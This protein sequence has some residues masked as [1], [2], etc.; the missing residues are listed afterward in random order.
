MDGWIRLI[1]GFQPLMVIS[2]TASCWRVC[3]G[4]VLK[5]RRKERKKRKLKRKKEGREERRKVRKE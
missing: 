1:V 4:P 2:P 5:E 3:T